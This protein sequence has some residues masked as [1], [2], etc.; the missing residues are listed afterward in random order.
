MLGSAKEHNDS[1]SIYTSGFPKTMTYRMQDGK[2]Q[3]RSGPGGYLW[4]TS[5]DYLAGQ[6][7]SPVYN[8]DAIVLGVVKGDENGIGYFI[9]IGFADALLAQIRLREIRTAMQDFELLRR[10]FDWSGEVNTTTNKITIMYEKPVGGNPHVDNISLLVKPT[11]IRGTEIFDKLDFPVNDVKWT[12]LAGQ[13]GRV[14]ELV[15]VWEAVETLRSTLNLDRIDKVQVDI[16][17]TLSDG[18]VLRRKRITI[19]Y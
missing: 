8:D 2:I 6:S 15:D 10:Q 3:N 19:E 17:P 9:P 5:F 16:V 11:G 7:G 4:A 14:F 12:A 13:N 1:K 18:T